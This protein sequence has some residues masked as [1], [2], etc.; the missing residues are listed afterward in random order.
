MAGIQWI[1]DQGYIFS[2]SR[3]IGTRWSLLEVTYEPYNQ[4]LYKG[5]P[6]SSPYGFDICGEDRHVGGPCSEKPWARGYY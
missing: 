6:D 5:D 1:S 3:P 2:L 4:V